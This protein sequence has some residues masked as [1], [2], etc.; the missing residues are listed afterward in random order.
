[1]IKTA[2]IYV[3][4]AFFEIAGCFSLWLW[5][6]DGKSAWWVAPGTVSL[7]LFAWFLTQ[8]DSAAAGRAYAAYGGVYIG[9]S[10]IWLWTVEGT[11]PDRWDALG[12]LICLV[13][14]T[15][16]LFGPRTVP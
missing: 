14:A 12:A 13:G 4:A 7:L 6:R 11:R 3:A 16:I 8:V 9:A 5:L 2:T 1:M 10:L 15:V